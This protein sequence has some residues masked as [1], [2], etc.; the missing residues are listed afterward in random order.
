MALEPVT[1]ELD[2]SMH[3]KPPFFVADVLLGN[4]SV[5]ENE[6][7][8]IQVWPDGWGFVC[9]QKQILPAGGAGPGKF[10][11][12]GQKRN[13]TYWGNVYVIVA[14][15]EPSLVFDDPANSGLVVML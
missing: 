7:I 9:V 10:Q 1:K 8:E 6:P 11:V 4:V 14:W 3:Y 2:G 12:D 5:L 13:Y 15:P